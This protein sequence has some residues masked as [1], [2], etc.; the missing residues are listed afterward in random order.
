MMERFNFDSVA[1]HFNTHL[2]GQLPW[3]DTFMDGFLPEVASFFIRN[4]S[5]VYD[6][7]AST[8]NVE[9]RI[10]PFLLDRNIDF[11]P[12]EQNRE[13]VKNYKGQDWK[14]VNSDFT[15]VALQPFSFSTSILA[16]SFVPPLKRIKFISELCEAC[17]VGGAILFLEK[18]VNTSG[19]VGTIFNRI[20]WRNKLDAKEPLQQIVDKELGLS[21]VQYPLYPQEIPASSHLIWSWGDFRAYLYVQEPTINKAIV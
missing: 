11:T 17:E 20:T 8:G 3:Y 9:K 18:F 21:G 15:E 5:R 1:D 2:T 6:L 16:M 14:V 19:V 10:S 12:I 7:G 13:M 4:N